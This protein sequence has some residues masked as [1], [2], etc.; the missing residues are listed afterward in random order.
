MKEKYRPVIDISNELGDQLAMQYQQ[1]IGILQWSIELGRINIIT[2]MS[3][4]SSFNVSSREGHL[5]AAYW[6]FEYLYSH[7]RGGLVV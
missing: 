6:M 1:M 3:F 5:E 4:L 7:K 2:E